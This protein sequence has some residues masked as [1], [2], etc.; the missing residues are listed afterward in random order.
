[1]PEH[2]EV[3][4][5]GREMTHTTA[6]KCIMAVD[7]LRGLVG[8]PADEPNPARVAADLNRVS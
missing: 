8:Q 2:T 4:P 3:D 5:D 6:E 1:M 7:V